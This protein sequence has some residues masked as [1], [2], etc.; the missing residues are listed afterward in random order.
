MVKKLMYGLVA[1]LLVP[2][3]IL[4]DEVPAPAAPAPDVAV[5]AEQNSAVVGTLEAEG[6]NHLPAQVDSR[7]WI[8]VSCKPVDETLR[9]QLGL[10]AG[11]GLVIVQ[12]AEDSP[13][14][15]AGLQVHDIILQIGIGEKFHKVNDMDRLTALLQQADQAK[16]MFSV[17]RA[18]KPLNFSTTPIRLYRKTVD[19]T[20]K[21]GVAVCDANLLLS[22]NEQNGLSFKL[23]GPVIAKTVV[24]NT[25]QARAVNL[26][27]DLSVIITK[28]G[29]D[30]V[31][32]QIQKKGRGVWTMRED[33]TAEQ[34]E[35]V[36]QAVGEALGYL[37]RFVVRRGE[38]NGHPTCTVQFTSRGRHEGGTSF[39]IPPQTRKL[40]VPAKSPVKPE[41]PITLSK[42]K[43]RLD[44]LEK[45]QE[46]AA[47]VFNELK[48]SLQHLS[49]KN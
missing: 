21:L 43:Q 39:S 36:S 32:I 37:S 49:P 19:D 8:G 16:V 2:V 34:P 38:N 42:A 5:S 22:P 11:N 31:E 14:K 41:S 48:Q 25:S 13:A 26:P 35:A 6:K 46:Q 45:Q 44:E 18:G 17:L 20:L 30:P 40:H 47:K 7:I 33:E 9:A 24:A 12:I 3:W 23:A 29:R 4:A 1:A 10:D 28:S 15:T 27:D